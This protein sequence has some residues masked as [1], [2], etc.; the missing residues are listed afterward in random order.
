MSGL[1]VFA[2]T[3]D[4]VFGSIMTVIASLVLIVVIT[5]L[6]LN[7]FPVSYLYFK[8]DI[9][10]ASYFSRSIEA[11]KGKKKKYILANLLLYLI[12]LGAFII[13]A[14]L[15]V[16]AI[17]FELIWLLFIP[18]GLLL[19]ILP[20]AVLSFNSCYVKVMEG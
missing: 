20:V 5:I 16:L 13:P 14:L 3:I 6:I 8:E 7:I 10:S 9:V 17:S 12:M 15:I 11:S 18:I 4:T 1:L 2:F 19:V